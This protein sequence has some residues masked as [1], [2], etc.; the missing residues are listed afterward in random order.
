[1]SRK[2]EKRKNAHATKIQKCT[3]GYRTCSLYLLCPFFTIC[4]AI[5]IVAILI[6]SQMYWLY[7]TPI[8]W[9]IIDPSDCIF[10]FFSLKEQQL[11]KEFAIFGT[12]GSHSE[13]Y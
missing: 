8:N 6:Q 2:D 5:L 1:M 13:H 10:E 12:L 4:S 7:H 3:C 9:V 11:F